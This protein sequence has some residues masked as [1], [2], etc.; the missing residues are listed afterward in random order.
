MTTLTVKTPG[1]SV[2][3]TSIF[4]PSEAVRG[5]AGRSDCRLYV[6]GDKKTPA[7]WQEPQVRFLSAREQEQSPSRLL[8]LLPWNHY[9]RK[10]S[11]YLLAITEGA[12]IIVDTDDDNI[13]KASWAMPAFSGVFDVTRPEGGF[14]NMYQAFTGQ[15]IWPRGFPL[16]RILDENSSPMVAQKKDVRVGVWQGLADGDPD[17]DAIYRL[18]NNRPCNF[19]ERSPLVLD[20]GTLCPFN[21][22]NTAFCRAAF[23]L[24][25]LPA[26]VTFRYTDIL[27]GLIAQPI[28]WAAGY[29]LGFTG[30]T[31]VQ[32]RNPHNYLKDFESEIPCYLHPDRVV[33]I[34]RQAVSATRSIPENLLRVY[35][36]LIQAGLVPAG[37][38]KLLEAWLYDLNTI[39][40]MS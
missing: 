34:A 28:L 26:L 21:S 4:R 9:C 16:N 32:E 15:F 31:V 7:D 14:V 17:V 8:Q 6:A 11:A 3:M 22:Q 1:Y 40:Q 25:Y 5:F 2:I 19:D 12:E 38:M 29:R 18:T 23:P 39:A 20:E 35:E 30:A 33:E 13:P 37:E 36:N 10:Q 27:R 24:L